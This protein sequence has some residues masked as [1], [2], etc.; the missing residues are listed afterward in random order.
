MASRTQRFESR[1]SM[2]GKRF[3][4]FH[5]REK[6]TEKLQVHHHDFYEVYFF[7]SGNVEYNVEGKSYHLNK[8]DLLLMGCALCYSFQILFV[9]F[10]GADQDPIRLNFIQVNQEIKI[11]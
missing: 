1:Q 11:F 7:I 10:F 2:Q 4:V 9:E 3:E 5:Y 8:G 6:K